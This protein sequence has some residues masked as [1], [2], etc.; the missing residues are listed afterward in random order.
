MFVELK[1]T[2]IQNSMTYNFTHR[3]KHEEFLVSL[4]DAVIDPET[5]RSMKKININI[6]Q[7]TVMFP[8]DRWR[9]SYQ[10]RLKSYEISFHVITMI[11]KI[12]GNGIGL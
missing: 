12:V 9:P 5:R 1:E 8:N 3:K 7:K 4:S 6:F 10:G 11:D 2:L